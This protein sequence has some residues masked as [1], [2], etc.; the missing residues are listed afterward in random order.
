MSELVY[1]LVM[2]SYVSFGID[3]SMLLLAVDVRIRAFL[4]EEVS[5]DIWKASVKILEEKPKL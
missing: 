2:Q 1:L 3:F 4:G 5:T